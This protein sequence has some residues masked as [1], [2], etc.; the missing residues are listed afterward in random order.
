MLLQRSEI[1][2]K[3]IGGSVLFG[4]GWGMSGFCPGPAIVG[5]LAG[6]YLDSLIWMFGMVCGYLSFAA[7]ATSAAAKSK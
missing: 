6:G 7:H 1:D 2:F 3:L 5:S 4:L